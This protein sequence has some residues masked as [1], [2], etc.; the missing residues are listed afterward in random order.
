[1]TDRAEW[2]GRVG[3]TW[4]AEWQRTDRSFAALTERLLGAATDAAFAQAL[5]IGCGAGEVSLALARANPSA[6][7]IGVDVSD[8]LLAAAR[9]RGAD[10]PN[11]AFE[12]GDAAGWTRAGVAP[13][14]LVSRHGVMFFPEPV[15]AFAHFADVAAA[16]ARLAFTCFRDPSENAWASG[17]AALL[18]PGLGAPPP[19]GEPGPFAFA[20]KAYV[21]RILTEAGWRDVTFEAVDF[22]YV[23]GAGDDPVEDA[24]SYFL[25]IGPAAR[26][27][28]QMEEH[29]RAAFAER[30]R[31]FLRDHLENGRVA[32]QAGA[33]L[34]TARASV[35]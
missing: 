14:L 18:P 25:V 21:E 19:P 24:L 35:R 30:L 26:A 6:Q 10:L 34:V 3:R 7:V 4:A 5:D 2:E 20:D 9:V 16:D 23:A 33:W 1:M 8:E 27:A 11:L 28:A 12:L 32:L 17:L 15:A 22:P 13:D 29:E 31:G